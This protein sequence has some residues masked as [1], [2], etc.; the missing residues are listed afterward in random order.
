M[1]ATRCNI[2]NWTEQ[3]GDAGEALRLYRELLLAQER[4]L[5]ERHP[6]V[7]ITRANIAG[8]TWQTGDAP[9]S[10]RLYNDLLSDLERVLGK[11]HPDTV[12]TRAW[13]QELEGDYDA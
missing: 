12:T 8:W 10:L 11:D 9:E 7:L 2:A 4:V 6:E 13:I 5:G 1:L 3:T